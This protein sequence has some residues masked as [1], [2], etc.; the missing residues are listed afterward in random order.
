[1]QH[2]LAVAKQQ[3]EALSKAYG[4]MSEA[5]EIAAKISKG[6]KVSSQEAKKLMET[7]PGLSMGRIMAVRIPSP[8]MQIASCSNISPSKRLSV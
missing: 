7:N 1:M 5:F 2:E 3:S 8:I 6:G 4:D